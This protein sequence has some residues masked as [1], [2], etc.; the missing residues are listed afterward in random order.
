MSEP[1]LTFEETILKVLSGKA[2]E[3]ALDFAAFL[4]ANNFATGENHGTVTHEGNVIAYIHMD[5]K[6]E[7]PGPW[8]VWPSVTG[9]VPEGFTL[10]ERMKEVAWA[11]VNVCGKCG[12]ECAPGSTKTVYGKEFDNI[13]GAILQFTNPDAESLQCVKTMLQLIKHDILN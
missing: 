1:C 10:D 9:T 3:N 12:G 7:I 5:G 13:C 6:D 8:T 2:Q 11:N 4:K